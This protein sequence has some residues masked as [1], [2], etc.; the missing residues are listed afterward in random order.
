MM[1]VMKWLMILM[2]VINNE[3]NDDINNDIII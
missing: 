3:S 2:C 1:I